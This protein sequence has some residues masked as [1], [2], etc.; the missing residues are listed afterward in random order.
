MAFPDRYDVIIVGA[1]AAGLAAA[2]ELA[3]AGISVAIVEARERIGGRIATLRDPALGYPVEL[4]AEFIHGRPAEIW[5]PLMNAGARVAEVKGDAWCSTD[6]LA[7]CDFFDS[8]HQI[9]GR[10]DDRAPD[11]SFADFL[12]ECFPSAQDPD[13]RELKKYALG[14]VSGFNAADPKLVGVHWLVKGMRHEQEIEGDRAFRCEHGYQDLIDIFRARLTS[15]SLPIHLK[16][17]VHAIDWRPGDVRISIQRGASEV[18]RAG[19]V[20]VTVPL[21]VLQARD[22]EEGAIRFNPH[23]P[24]EKYA[25]LD[26]MEMGK[27][28]RLVLKFRERFWDSICPA[29]VREGGLSDMSFLFSDDEWF[30]TWWTTMPARQ[31]LIT[32]WAPFACAERLS[33]R[34]RPFVVKQGLTTLSRLL[35]V[36]LPRLEQLFEAA[37]VHDW[38]SDPLSRGAYSYGKVGADGAQAALARPIQNTLFFAGE[39]TDTSGSNGTVHGA[40][41]S[42]FRSAREILNHS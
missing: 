13:L 3:R 19:K 12:E 22:S 16:T 15:A 27:V 32:G 10:M 36:N 4:G 5:D 6:Q 41:K 8:V 28:I 14:Y 33:G 30:P 11:L 23:L 31:P 7:P 42:G 20:I 18:L 21:A 35:R 24:D 1:G 34:E 37:Y 2:T 39:A 29:N 38:Q 26:R 9:L 40:L 17:V 25:A